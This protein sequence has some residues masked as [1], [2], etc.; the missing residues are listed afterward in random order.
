M[1]E[2]EIQDKLINKGKVGILR[3]SLFGDERYLRM[4]IGCPK[5]MLQDGL[6]RIKMALS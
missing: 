5:N 4:N 6:N 2:D 1:T 3:G